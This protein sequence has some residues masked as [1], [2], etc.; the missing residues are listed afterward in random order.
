MSTVYKTEAL[1]ISS[2]RWHESS[3]IV[4]FFSGDHGYLKVIA[5]GALRPKSDF[6][7]VLEALNHVEIVVSHRESR[8]LQILTAASVINPYLEV[9][10][11]LQKTAVAFSI[12]ELIRKLFSVH[13]PVEA[14]FRYTLAL[15]SALNSSQASDLK[16]YLWHFLLILSETLGFGWS[17]NYCAACENP[18]KEETVLLDYRNGDLVCGRC[19]NRSAAQGVTLT[20]PQREAL[21]EFSGAEP[22]QLERLA[23]NRLLFEGVDLTEILLRHLAYHT[24]VPLELKSLKWYM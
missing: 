12:L 22:W 7:G 18:P 15:L 11:D 10:D 3:K 6:R 24:E 8:G 16:T 17:L 4:Q 20:A 23:D 19:K 14:F 2:M 1:V 21:I 9:R 13:E 5:K